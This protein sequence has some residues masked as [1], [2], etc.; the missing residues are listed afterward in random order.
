MSKR[1]ILGVLVWVGLAAG[2]AWAFSASYDQKMTQ[3]RDVYQSRVSLKDGLFRMEMTVDGMDSIII[4]NA[5]GTFTV[6][7][8]EGM[9]MKTSNLRAGQRP[10]R[11]ADNY[12]QYLQQ[13]HAERT[14][15][16]TVDGRACDIYRFSDPEAGGTTTV[17]VWKD[18]MFPIRF[19]TETAEGK[20]V[21]E[22]SN[23]QLGAAI[24]DEAFQ[25]PAGVQVMDMGAL[26][27]MQ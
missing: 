4:H 22:L 12:T 3:G 23:I 25:L 10:V 8:S 16:E 14:G 5:D 21:T 18:K 17:W 15:E 11:G 20:T 7:P 13:Q 9:A 27:G 26:M 19:E 24:P 1:T 6:M 2:D